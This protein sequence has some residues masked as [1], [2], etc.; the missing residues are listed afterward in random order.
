MHGAKRKFAAVGNSE[1]REDL[2][3][4]RFHRAMGKIQALRQPL[5]RELRDVKLPRCQQIAAARRSLPSWAM[6]GTQDLMMHPEAQRFM[7]QRTP[8]LTIK[9]IDASHSAACRTPTPSNLIEVAVNCILT[10][11]LEA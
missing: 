5:C 7:A 6:V 3:Q 8:A 9:E 10:V 4:V 1:L 11:S 2:V